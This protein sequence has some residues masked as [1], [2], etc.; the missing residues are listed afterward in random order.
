M[1]QKNC[2]QIGSLCLLIVLGCGVATG[3]STDD[4]DDT[5]SSDGTEKTLKDLAADHGIRIG[6]NYDYEL[7]SETHDTIFGEEFNA[8]TVYM[9][10][11]GGVEHTSRD[12][13]DFTTTDEMVDFGT[14]RGMEV[15]GQ[16]LVW[17]EDTPDW[18][19]STPLSEIE[20]VMN[21]HIDA[22][23]DRYKGR[24]NLWNVVN[25]AIDDEGNI[26][27]NNR[28]AQAMGADYISKAFIRAQAADPTAILY[29][30]EFDIES[31][32]AKF[33]GVKNLLQ[34]LLDQGV[35]VHALGWQMHVRPG[36]FDPETLLARMNEIADMGLDN[37]I[38]ELDVELPEEAT[39]DDYEQQKETFKSV[40]EVFLEAKRHQTLVFWGL[41][42][43][44]PYWLTDGHPLLFD[45]SFGK[46]AAYY[47]AQE[48][49]LEP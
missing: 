1:F 29:Y 5:G 2:L 30:N 40:I 18:V 19:K 28:W 22:V 45:E 47:G 9:G 26:R 43:G 48:A 23:V 27:L 42:D 11:E 3:D 17:F 38:T 32:E 46:K 14:T 20:A 16:S 21:E 4:P 44:S 12:S 49:F 34:E 31:N 10:Y 13:Y 36:S 24:V 35:P 33:N 15:F 37:Y 39:S 41:R 6:S 8:I 7:R 25:E